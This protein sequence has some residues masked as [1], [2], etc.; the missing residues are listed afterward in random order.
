MT[1]GYGCQRRRGKSC[2]ERWDDADSIKAVCLYGIQGMPKSWLLEL[3]PAARNY[4]S[5]S[6]HLLHCSI[7]A[8]RGVSPCSG[9]QEYCVK[10]SQGISL[11]SPQCVMPFSWQHPATGHSPWKGCPFVS[12]H[13]PQ[14]QV[15]LYSHPVQCSPQ[16]ES[17]ISFFIFTL[18]PVLF[19][20]LRK[21]FP[22]SYT[23]TFKT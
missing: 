7:L 6:A 19:D 14:P 23:L 5:F 15:S 8:P 16:R 2:V 17:T 9:S 18:S 1:A 21:R 20:L 3:R 12:I 22:V 13:P 10:R 11:H 4:V